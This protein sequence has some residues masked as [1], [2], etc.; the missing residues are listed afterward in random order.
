MATVSFLAGL[1]CLA[2]IGSSWGFNSS[3]LRYETAKKMAWGRKNSAN[4][5]NGVIEI[6]R[7]QIGVR[8]TNGENCGIAIARYLNYCGIKSPAPWC[9]AFVSYCFGQAGYPQPKTAWSP[10]LFPASRLVKVVSSGCLSPGLVY[11]LYFPS[12]QRIAHCGIMERLQGDFVIGIEGN[13]NVAGSRD[14][15]GVYRKLRHRRTIY[16]FANWRKPG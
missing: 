2:F 6:A 14:G 9:A 7:S 11:G 10:A 8:E 16:Y 3:T 4:D 1:F 13:T 5:A 12:L 15:G